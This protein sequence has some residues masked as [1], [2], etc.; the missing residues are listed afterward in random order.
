MQFLLRALCCTSFSDLDAQYK[1][2]EANP[3]GKGITEYGNI[4]G[5]SQAGAPVSTHKVGGELG[6]G[7]ELARATLQS[8]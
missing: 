6:E 2:K 5:G 4:P 8:A 3:P 1:C 7:A